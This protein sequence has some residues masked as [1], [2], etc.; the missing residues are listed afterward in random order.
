MDTE[1]QDVAATPAGPADAEGRRR[2]RPHLYWYLTFRCNLSCAHCWVGASPRIDTAGEL[3]P[4]EAM[5]VVDQIDELGASACTLSGGELLTRP[6]ALDIVEA[7]AGRGVQVWIETNG[8]LIRDRF[9]ELA[10]RI[11]QRGLLGMGISLDGGTAET[12]ERLRGPHTFE[13][14]VRNLRRLKLA[15]V[16]FSVQCIL[17]RSNIETIPALYDLAAELWPSLHRLGFG[18]LNPLGRG[19]DLSRELGVGFGDLDRILTLIADHEARFPGMTVVKA[20]PAAIPPRH[21]RTALKAASIATMASC[22]FPLL[23]VLPDGEVTICALSRDNPELRF[24]NVRDVTL[25]QLWGLAR[26]ELLRQRYLATEHLQGICGD[27]IWNQSCRGGCRAWAYETGGSF[28]ASYP[29]CAELAAAGDF[30]A[31]YRRSSFAAPAPAPLPGCAGCGVLE[32]VQ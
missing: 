7:L 4:A 11:Q 20:P 31:A 18:L 22:R 3:T 21:L 10:P 12:H 29:L 9:L 8:L 16:R 17:N 19:E 30:P 24:G 26:I 25:K 32:P 27:C 6:D 2:Y 5:R 13:R 15:G 1:L 14:T 23:G 28:D